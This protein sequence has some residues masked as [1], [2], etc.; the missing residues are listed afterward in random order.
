MISLRSGL[1]ILASTGASL[2]EVVPLG[3]HTNVNTYAAV[4]HTEYHTGLALSSSVA[5]FG[6]L[7]RVLFVIFIFGLLVCSFILLLLRGCCAQQKYTALD[8]QTPDCSLGHPRDFHC[9]ALAHT[10]TPICSNS[11]LLTYKLQNRF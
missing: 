1:C 3:I 7:L 2:R 5:G 10:V 11:L 8:I 9:N 4:C 6:F